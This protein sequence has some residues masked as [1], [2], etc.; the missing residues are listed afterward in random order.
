MELY[1]YMRRELGPCTAIFQLPMT[2]CSY[3]IQQKQNKFKVCCA[4]L[5]TSYLIPLPAGF[6]VK[7]ASN[8]FP[9]LLPVY[10]LKS[11]R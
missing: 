4:T 9:T 11:T 10:L 2:L 1:L 8:S 7:G 3:E 6:E 5:Q